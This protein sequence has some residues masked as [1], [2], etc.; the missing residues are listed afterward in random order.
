[1]GTFDQ[2]LE[3]GILPFDHTVSPLSMHKNLNE[4][5]LSHIDGEIFQTG[6]LMFFNVF[7]GFPIN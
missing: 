5:R 6:A 2:G 3:K 4:S 7:A 1:M